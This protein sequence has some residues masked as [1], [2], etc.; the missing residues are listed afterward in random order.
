MTF[1]TPLAILVTV[2]LS[3][4]ISRTGLLDMFFH[5]F[6]DMTANHID[7]NAKNRTIAYKTGV[8]KSKLNQFHTQNKTIGEISIIKQ[9]AATN[10]LTI[11]KTTLI[12]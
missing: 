9:S 1:E 11:V 2:I 4:P 12:V 3:S 10:A 6:L 5:V 8:S 7:Q